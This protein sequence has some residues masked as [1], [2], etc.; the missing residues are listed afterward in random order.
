MPMAGWKQC[1]LV[2]ESVN[3]GRQARLLRLNL[4]V[5]EQSYVT[6]SVVVQLIL[7]GSGEIQAYFLCG[8]LTE[9]E[10]VLP[11]QPQCC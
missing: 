11:A 6:Q 9:L 10:V 7:D 1:R 3:A 2:I 8:G 5:P 4:Y